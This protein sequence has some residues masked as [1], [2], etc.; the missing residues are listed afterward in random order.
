[1]LDPPLQRKQK[2][3]SIPIPGNTRRSGECVRALH[4]PQAPGQTPQPLY[5]LP[6]LS[7]LLVEDDD[8]DALIVDDLLSEALPDAR[9][10]RSRRFSDALDTL[11][12]DVDCVLLDLKLPDA[13]GIDTV[14]RLLAGYGL[15][16][17]IAQVRLPNPEATDAS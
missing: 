2:Q 6:V 12:A 9:I 1:M 8:G 13:E 15:L 17:V 4:T 14:V 16:M 11:D 10:I 5:D 7:V 3:H